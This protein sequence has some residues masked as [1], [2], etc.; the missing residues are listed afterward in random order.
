MLK[1]SQFSKDVWGI[2]M[3][4][5]LMLFKRKLSIYILHRHILYLTEKKQGGLTVFIQRPHSVGFTVREWLM[6]LV[7]SDALLTPCGHHSN[8]TSEAG[9]ANKVSMV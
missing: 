1:G 3:I 9:G 5:W 8:C 4:F 7:S 6:W 2:R